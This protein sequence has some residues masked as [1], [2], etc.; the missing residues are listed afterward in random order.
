MCQQDRESLWLDVFAWADCRM[1]TDAAIAAAN[2]ACDAEY[3]PVDH[4]PALVSAY[5]T[6]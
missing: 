3:G 1:S 5:W 4:V 2:A 6:D